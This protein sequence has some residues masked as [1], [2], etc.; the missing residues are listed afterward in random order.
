[1]PILKDPTIR[2]DP[3]VGDM[4]KDTYDADNDGVVD[5]SEKLEGKTKEEVQDHVKFSIVI[6]IDTP[7]TEGTD[8]G[9]F[10]FAPGVA[11][12][13]EEVYIMAKTAPGT[14][15]TLTVDVNK[16]GTTIFT[17][18][19]NRPSISGTDKTGT[20]G[21]PDVTSFAK[22]DLFTIDVDVSTAET[23]VADVV[24][25]IRGKQKVA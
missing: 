10:S 5:N 3:P 20:S 13:I 22:N 2:K 11:G 7:E 21:I 25:L 16:G 17:T 18:Q 6:P 9:V 12:T 1:M 23:S 8:K 15:K 4:Q 14:D 24:V 19:G